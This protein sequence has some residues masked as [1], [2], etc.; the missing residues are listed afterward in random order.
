MSLLSFL[1]GLLFPKRKTEL[2]LETCEELPKKLSVLK[3]YPFP[4]TALGSYD[5]EVV[6]AA[7]VETKFH[8]STKGT[9]LLGALLA[10]YIEGRFYPLSTAL[11]IPMPLSKE[12]EKERGYNQVRRI[13][14]AAE[15][16]LPGLVIHEALTRV[17]NT[18]PQTELSKNERKENLEDA[19]TC[20]TLDPSYTYLLVDDVTTTG[21]TLYEAIRTLQ[22]AGATTIVPIALAH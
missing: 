3:T 11:V 6:R 8:G 14:E 9:K 15:E 13:C 18:T 2:V 16:L 5:N 10:S 12:R 21:A 17:K 22:K 4:T 19:F 20:L 1:H 7:I